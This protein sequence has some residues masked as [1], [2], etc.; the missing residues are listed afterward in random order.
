MAR[1]LPDETV[2]TATASGAQPGSYAFLVKQL[3][4]NSQQLSRGFADR[5]TTPVGMTSVS[6]ELGKGKVSTQ[7]QLADLNGGEGVRRGKINITDTAGQTAEIDLSTATSIDEVLDAINN[8]ATISV[9]ASIDEDRLVVR[10]PGHAVGSLPGSTGELP[11]LQ[12]LLAHRHRI[13]LQPFFKTQGV[14]EIQALENPGR[15]R[16]EHRRIVDV[17]GQPVPRPVGVDGDGQSGQGVAAALALQRGDQ[18]GLG[19]VVEG[20]RG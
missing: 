3:V 15:R 11:H 13:P 16:D 9:T 10:R 5:D 1:E 12:V 20:P 2:L 14:V 4:S 8:E 17:V 6:F 19:V 18:H 7:T